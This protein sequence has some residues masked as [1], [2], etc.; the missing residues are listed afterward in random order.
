VRRLAAPPQDCPK[1]GD[2][3]MTVADAPRVRPSLGASAGHGRSAALDGLRGIAVLAVLTYHA[4]YGWARGGFLGVDMF[5]VLS[6]YLITGGLLK[7]RPTGVRGHRAAYVAFL[8]RRCARLMPALAVMLAALWALTVTVGPAADRERLNACTAAA[9]AYVMNLPVGQQLR[10]SAQWHITWSLAAEEQFYLLWPIVLAA[11]CALAAR[12]AL[13]RRRTAAHMALGLFVGGVVWQCWLRQG[14]PNTARVFFAPDGRSLIL[15]MGCA[16]ALWEP[17]VSHAA[18]RI[19]EHRVAALGVLTLAAA[20]A[21][22]R[23]GAGYVPFAA[24]LLV[25]LG[26]AAVIAASSTDERC[27]ALRP[28]VQPVL[29]AVGRISYSLYL[30]H[31]VAYRIADMLL[32][33]GSASGEALRWVLTLAFGIASFTLIEKPA[34]RWLTN[35]GGR[36]AAPATPA[37]GA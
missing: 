19:G 17:S 21:L 28:L 34:L 37:R 26:T 31:E 22:G 7:L 12:A 8:R 13:P 32:V 23:A 18:R 11:A 27:R 24:A 2:D 14:D 9:A 10:C 30:W 33:R 5:F 20:L 36:P 6:G 29:V 4:H 25:G 15:L 35:N 1:E 3:A 16:L